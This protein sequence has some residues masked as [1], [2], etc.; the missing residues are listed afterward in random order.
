MLNYFSGCSLQTASGTRTKPL[1]TP[2]PGKEPHWPAMDSGYKTNNFTAQSQRYPSAFFCRA[3]G[4]VEYF[5][6]HHIVV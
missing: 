4:G 6:Y 1:P 5:H 2:S 3:F